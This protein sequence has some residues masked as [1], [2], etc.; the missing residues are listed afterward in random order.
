MKQTTTLFNLLNPRQP[1]E[2]EIYAAA[3]VTIAAFDGDLGR[4]RAWAIDEAIRFNAE[5]DRTRNVAAVRLSRAIKELTRAHFIRVRD[6]A[7]PP[8]N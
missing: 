2:V 6:G 1:S 3:E 4:A 8:Q 7:D 5:G